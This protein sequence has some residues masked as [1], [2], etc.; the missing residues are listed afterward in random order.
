M[1][2][3]IKLWLMQL[4]KEEIILV[5][6]LLQK[7]EQEAEVKPVLGFM[8]ALESSDDFTHWPLELKSEKQATDDNL[9][10]DSCLPLSIDV[11]PSETGE[12]RFYRV[13]AYA[14]KDPNKTKY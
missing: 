9:T 12:K 10:T 4:E 6:V 3:A 8:Y 2:Q 14:P 5:V 1:M 11:D 7:A 13:R